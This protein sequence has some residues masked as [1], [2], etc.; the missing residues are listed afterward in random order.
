MKQPMQKSEATI[1]IKFTDK[2]PSDLAQMV[3][4]IAIAFTQLERVIYLAAKR[5]AKVPL[6]EWEGR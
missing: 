5:N 6:I 3:G 2:W 4:L 1:R